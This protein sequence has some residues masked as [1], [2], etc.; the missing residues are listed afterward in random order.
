MKNIH[1]PR[2]K[3]NDEMTNELSEIVGKQINEW[4]ND[5]NDLE[6]CI[7]ICKQI[8]EKEYTL[9]EDGYELAKRF[10]REG[11]TPDRELVELLD[12]LSYDGYDIEKKH[13]KQWVIDNNLSLNLPIGTKAKV[14]LIRKGGIEVEI[15]R[16]YPE[17]LEYG[18]WHQGMKES[19]ESSAII[20][21]SEKIIL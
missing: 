18:V 6:E 17:T 4:C 7:S 5:E 9:N 11:F 12:Y 19:K 20:V 21:K 10:E 2:P 13:V 8:F 16:H 3:W 1:P 14:N 15:T